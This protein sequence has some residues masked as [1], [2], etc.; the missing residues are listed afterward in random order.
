[1]GKHKSVERKRMGNIFHANS[2]QRKV[3][4]H[5]ISRNT[6]FQTKTLSKGKDRSNILI[7]WSINQ[8][9]IKL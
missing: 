4:S 9:Y 7:K 2:N 6:D 1:M 8:E 3:A 5:I